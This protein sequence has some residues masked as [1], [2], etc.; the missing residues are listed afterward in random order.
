MPQDRGHQLTYLGALLFIVG[1]Y[2]P[3]ATIPVY[4]DVTYYRVAN[5]EAIL[6]TLF[7]IAGP[8]MIF[9]RKEPLA[10]VSAVGAWGVL[11]FPALKGMFEKED[12]SML[13]KLAKKASDPLAEF[14]GDLFLKI[15]N[16][17]WG[18]YI[19]LLGLIML[20]VGAVMTTLQARKA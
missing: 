20:T 2:A 11:L 1:V 15:D 12:T 18:G 16:F 13:G 8:A 9:L 14:A 4:G 10:F 6:V 19:L 5:V 3:L 17:S 7:A